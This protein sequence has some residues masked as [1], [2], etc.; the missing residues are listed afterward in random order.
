MRGVCSLEIE[1]SGLKGL[2][3]GRGGGGF[4]KV[5]EFFL[6]LKDFKFFE[7]IK[8]NIDKIEK[9]L[10]EEEE[11]YSL[12]IEKIFINLP[13]DKAEFLTVEDVVPLSLRKKWVMLK[14]IE[15]AK[16]YIENIVLDWKK[17]LLHHI[18]LKYEAENRIYFHLPLNLEAKNLKL[19]SFLVYIKRK[20]YEEMVEMFDNIERK[21]AG[22]IWEPIS[23]LS[24]GEASLDRI[25]ILMKENYT[26]CAGIKEG[27][28]FVEKLSF[29]EKDIKRAIQEKFF[30]SSSVAEKLFEWYIYFDDILS[31]DKMITIKDKKNYI[32]ISE[33]EF[34]LFIKEII[35]SKLEEILY[36]LEGKIEENTRFL[37]LGNIFQK[38]NFTN[39]LRKEIPSL[40]VNSFSL[41]TKYLSLYGCITYGHL[42]YFERFNLPKVSL[43]QKILNIYQGYF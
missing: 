11:K 40:K 9:I 13:F 4:E 34:L 30:V 16:R 14:D 12:E 8:R 2:I 18:I 35:L 22:F 26:L 20:Y 27:E 36:L 24:I 37:F 28:M 21:F 41:P 23:S 7:G 39:F 19:K 42:R 29:G 15:K 25:S 33:E 1:E 10:R 43:W 5:E 32:R 3:V 6:E 38:K 17:Y 31:K